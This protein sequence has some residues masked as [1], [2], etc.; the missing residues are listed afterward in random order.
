M[1]MTADPAHSAT[2][3]QHQRCFPSKDTIITQTPPP[4]GAPPSAGNAI[5]TRCREVPCLLPDGLK[6]DPHLHV[7]PLQ[8]VPPP[9]AGIL[10]LLRCRAAARPS[11]LGTEPR[12]Q[13]VQLR[14]WA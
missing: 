2:P 9:P 3:D 12:H 6:A 8:Q 5:L 11:G 10:I 1:I 7:L 14:A 4:A 13:A